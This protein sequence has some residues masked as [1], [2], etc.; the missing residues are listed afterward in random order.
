M[1]QPVDDRALPHDEPAQG[2]KRLAERPH[3]HVYVIVQPEIAGGAASTLPDHA[4]RVRVVDQY[5]RIV[6]PGGLH[7]VGKIDNCS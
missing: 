4:G 3:R 6:F 5:A 1:S 2:R 7:Q